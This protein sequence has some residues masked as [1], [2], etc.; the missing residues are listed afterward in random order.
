MILYNEDGKTV[1]V[2]VSQ[3]NVLLN[4]GWS[5]TKP[6]EKPSESVE[7]TPEEVDTSSEETETTVRKKRIIKKAGD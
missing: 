5:K 6:E 2:D 4:A 7:T 1:N 3:V